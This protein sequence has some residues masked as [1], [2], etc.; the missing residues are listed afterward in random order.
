MC[1]VNAD[2]VPFTLAQR[3]GIQADIPGTVSVL[4]DTFAVMKISGPG[5]GIGN[6][7]YRKGARRRLHVAGLFFLAAILAYRHRPNCH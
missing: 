2:T 7:V 6:L 4:D 5:T 1:S 3:L